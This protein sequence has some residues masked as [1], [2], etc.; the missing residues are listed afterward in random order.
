LIPEIIEVIAFSPSLN[1]PLIA[2]IGRWAK[3]LNKN[4][5]FLPGTSRTTIRQ[6]SGPPP[7]IL[8]PYPKTSLDFELEIF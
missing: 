5:L 8:S 3:N 4:L 7:S 2:Y 1:L 6:D